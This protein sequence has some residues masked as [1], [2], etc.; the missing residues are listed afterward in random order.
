MIGAVLNK[1][2]T[3]T[4]LLVETR[5]CRRFLGEDFLRVLEN[6]KL[7]LEGLFSLNVSHSV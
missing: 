7:F 2:L 1:L 3:K 4:N 5:S 6:V